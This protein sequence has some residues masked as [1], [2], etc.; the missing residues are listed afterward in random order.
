MSKTQFQMSWKTDFPWVKEGLQTGY[1]SCTLCKKDNIFYSSMGRSALKSHSKSQK[2]ILNE[3]NASKSIPIKTFFTTSSSDSKP[4]TSKNPPSLSEAEYS[5]S[6]TPS[7]SK[8][9]ITISE[10]VGS[11]CTSG[12]GVISKNEKWWKV[13]DE[14]SE[15]EVL[16]CLHT[17]MFHNS[18]RNAESSVHLFKRMFKDSSIA[19][20][21]KLGKD[22]IAYSIVHGIAPYLKHQLLSKINKA[23]FFVLCFDESKCHGHSKWI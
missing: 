5:K 21:L 22:K 4:S 12:E 7:T 8:D 23:D 10:A 20:D 6:P 18:L 13:K 15:C 14:V 9:S 3:K 17:V 1:A 2:H 11:K 16:W 19:Q